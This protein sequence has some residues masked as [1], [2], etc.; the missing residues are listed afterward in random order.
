VLKN[1]PRTKKRLD[2]IWDEGIT[3]KRGSRAITPKVFGKNYEWP[4]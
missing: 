1:S 2:D 3:A 4:F